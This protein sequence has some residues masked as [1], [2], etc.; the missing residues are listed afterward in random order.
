MNIIRGLMLFAV[1][2]FTF[3]CFAYSYPIR[4][5]QQQRGSAIDLVVFNDG[6]V[7]V[8]IVLELTQS[9]NTGFSPA[10]IGSKYP[11]LLP[12]GTSKTITTAVRLKQGKPAQFAFKYKFAFGDPNAIPDT[13]FVYRLP[14]PDNYRGVIQPYSGEYISN[15]VIDTGNSTQLLIPL[16]TPIVAARDGL[17]INVRGQKDTDDSKS[18]SSIG[19]FVSILHEDGTW[20]NYGWLMDKSV[21]VNPGD[22]VK[23]GQQIARS[24]SNPS[25]V[26]TYIIMV[27]NRNSF[28]LQLR[29]VPFKI[30]SAENESFDIT[31]FSGPVSPNLPA[32]YE[33]PKPGD[34]PWYPSESLLPQPKVPVDW[35]DD[36]MSPTQRQAIFRQR[37][38]EQTSLRNSESITGSQS[39]ITLAIVAIV[40]GI[41]GAFVAISSHPTSRPAGVRGV[42]W[43]LLRGS[44]WRHVDM[45]SSQ[46][47]ANAP[48][49]DRFT[50]SSGLVKLPEMPS[51]VELEPPSP[52]P[53]DLNSALGEDPESSD[54]SSQRD[55]LSS[56]KVALLSM[57]SKVIPSS[58]VCISN[59]RLTELVDYKLP[60]DLAEETVD[61]VLCNEKTRA[62]VAAILYIP[63]HDESQ[64]SLMVAHRLSVAGIQTITYDA[65]PK[66][67]DLKTRIKRLS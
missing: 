50:S 58:W 46:E 41:T 24:G 29:S 22:I 3:N 48:I 17:V 23:A 34:A 57:I 4:V 65:L 16:N 8:S 36:H 2:N 19:N 54:K 20:A 55:I 21:V 47:D 26:E 44:K 59:I 9:I 13:N 45:P 27:V 33:Q 43:G 14:I 31:S 42:L 11:H 37:I 12:A 15:N 32:Q 35:G 62:T 52:E 1:L 30:K 66:L 56:D 28:A 39:Y 38:A 53:N 10:V 40:L 49:F 51:V 61:F 63:D 18:E 67:S 25:S 64:I 6:P 60:L 7:F 5:E